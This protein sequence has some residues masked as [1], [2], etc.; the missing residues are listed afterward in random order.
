MKRCGT[1]LLVLCAAP[2]LGQ[3][4]AEV[5]LIRPTAFIGAE[6]TYYIV[7]DENPL[8]D[9]E[10][11]EHVR[12]RIAPGQRSLAVR[13]PKAMSY[14][15][16]ETRI[17]HE[18]KAGQ[19]AF[20]VISPKFDCV[21]IEAVDVREAAKQVANTTPRPAGRPVA[22]TEGRV[23]ARAAVET[24]EAPRAEQIAAAT[25]AWIEAFNSRDGARISALYDTDAILTDASETR[26]RIGAPAIAE[27]Y[28]SV[29]QRPTQRVAL[30]ERRIRLYG[31]TAIDSGTLTYFEMREGTA[32]TTS[33]RY[34]LTYRNRG[35][36][37]LIV[38]QQSSL[39]PH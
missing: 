28:K 16:A 25:A 2:A 22:Y 34:S 10:S 12:F 29:A 30:G 3:P 36:K 32:V 27:Y 9:I 35:G 21:T 5:T 37:W 23:A 18:F 1:L 31:E 24:A 13:C 14:Y 17:Q 7:V 20:F 26:P 11:R 6:S 39:A 19:P 33:G 8:F 15:Y 38:D 4:A